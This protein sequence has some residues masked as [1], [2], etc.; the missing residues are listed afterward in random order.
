MTHL[1]SRFKALRPA[2]EDDEDEN[3]THRR[4]FL[5]R[6]SFQ[7]Q[8]LREAMNTSQ[9]EVTQRRAT[10]SGFSA[11]FQRTT[12]FSSLSKGRIQVITGPDGFDN[13][14]MSLMFS[15]EFCS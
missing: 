4:E 3:P 6:E 13:S 5:E 12:D 10:S 7:V 1:S 15:L 8:G 14:W 2:D 9:P 11:E